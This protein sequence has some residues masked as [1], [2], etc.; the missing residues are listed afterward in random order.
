MCLN[1]NFEINSSAEFVNLSGKNIWVWK[2]YFFE[3]TRTLFKH[4]I[5]RNF[6]TKPL[7]WPV[8][9]GVSTRRESFFIPWMVAP[10]KPNLY[11]RLPDIQTNTFFSRNLRYRFLGHPLP[12]SCDLTCP[13]GCPSFFSLRH[14]R[15][16]PA[17][18]NK[19][20]NTVG[21][22]CLKG[23][24]GKFRTQ[25]KVFSISVISCMLRCNIDITW[26]ETKKKRTSGVKYW[27][28][29]NISEVDLYFNGKFLRTNKKIE[30]T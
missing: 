10:P 7:T 22:K 4:E 27:G 16:C 20:R 13:F 1:W 19:E 25:V 29:L 17:E 28:M 2:K 24:V 12:P 5:F 9:T 11:P 8:G 3:T 21:K 26:D 30:I 14:P 23:T 18:K 6:Y 15:W